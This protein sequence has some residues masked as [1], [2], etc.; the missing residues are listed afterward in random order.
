MRRCFNP[1]RDYTNRK[2]YL[3]LAAVDRMQQTHHRH[4]LLSV[5]RVLLDNSFLLR[6]QRSLGQRMQAALR[7]R[8]FLRWKQQFTNRHKQRHAVQVWLARLFGADVRRYF[9]I[10]QIRT[11]VGWRLGRSVLQAKAW[12]AWRKAAASCI[13]AKQTALGR[14]FYAWKRLLVGLDSN[15]TDLLQKKAAVVNVFIRC[16]THCAAYFYISIMCHC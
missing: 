6:A 11:T 16:V 15:K 2:H 12:R 7:R 13:K 14:V 8:L 4:Q 9:R 10:W 3:R 5:W 1:W